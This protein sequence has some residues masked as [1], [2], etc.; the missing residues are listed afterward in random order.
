[1]NVLTPPFALLSFAHV[2]VHEQVT[3]P[4]SAGVRSVHV[5]SLTAHSVIHKRV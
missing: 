4:C 1:M 2:S 3:W 5:L